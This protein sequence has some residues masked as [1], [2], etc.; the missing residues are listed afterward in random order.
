M[1]RIRGA[2][3]LLGGVGL[4]LLV[5]GCATVSTRSPTESLPP[6]GV[7]VPQ[8]E[9]WRQV[10]AE[11]INF[12]VP[13]DW[14]SFGS[15]TW[16][17]SGGSVSWGPGEPNPRRLGVFTVPRGLDPTGPPPPPVY[18][19]RITEVI[20]GVSVDLWIR[21]AGGQILTGA[22][23]T[24]P[25]LMNMTGEASSR[26]NAELHWTIFRTARITGKGL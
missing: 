26:R 11:G 15:N 19:N 9:E 7:P 1:G 12:C 5:S 2:A 24:T 6:C 21:D 3:Q 25:S 8:G 13:A 14:T 16:R 10:I 20:G 23:W 18:S 17:G 22:Q 4:L